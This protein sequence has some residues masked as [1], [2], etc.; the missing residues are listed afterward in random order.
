MRG[1]GTSRAQSAWTHGLLT[2][3]LCSMLL[4]ALAGCT[5]FRARPIDV[6]RRLDA[7]EA[8]R[9]DDPGLRRYMERALH[10]SP[11]P[12][13]PRSWSFE[14]LTVAADYFHADL[15]V[16]WAKLDAARAAVLTAGARPNP[17]LALSPSYDIS[18]EPGIS[19]WTLGFTLDIPIETAGKRGYRI[20][21]AQHLA[22]AARLGVAATAWKIRSHVR[23]SLIEWQAAERSEEILR[24]AL[25][26]GRQAVDLLE[27][28]FASGEASAREVQLVRIAA[29]KAALQWR[30]GQK[31]VSQARLAASAAVG[32]PEG[33]LDG[34]EL[35]FTA[36][37]ALPSLADAAPSRRE[38]LLNRSDVLGALADYDAT[39]S[40]LQLEIARQYPDVHLGPGFSHGFVASELENELSFG[41]SLTLPVLN[42]NRGPIAEAEAHR[43][44]AAARFNA[45]QARAIAQVDEASISYR[46][47]LAKLDTADRLLGEQRERMRSVQGL[48]DAG[49]ADRLTLVQAQGEL[50]ADEL[51]RTQALTEAQLALGALEDAMQRSAGSSRTDGL[52]ARDEPPTPE[53]HP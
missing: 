10:R 22:N 12:W 3:S 45:V 4:G 20:A 5:S 51:A 34:I 40:A 25:T 53:T 6:G 21:E 18:A 9:L 44:E 14:E 13:P 36:L 41:I 17:T 43:E 7:L 42:L 48:F 50:A 19:P 46:D 37:D 23:S 27:A 8:R 52:P 2:A 11:S 39:E 32:V 24:R 31:R 15:A 33:A 29:D 16:A 49:Q 47:A 28:R 35:S 38:A 26:A 30:D 1:R